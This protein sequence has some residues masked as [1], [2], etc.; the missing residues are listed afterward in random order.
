MIQ[1]CTETKISMING[2]KKNFVKCPQCLKSE[3]FYNFIPH[4]CADCNFHWGDIT[5]LMNNKNIRKLFY[6]NG[7]IN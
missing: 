3:W 1:I 6:I 7:E 2:V 5:A 4:Q